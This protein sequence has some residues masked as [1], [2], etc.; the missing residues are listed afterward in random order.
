MTGEFISNIAVIAIAV[1]FAFSLR[2]SDAPKYLIYGAILTA[3]GAIGLLN[4]YGAIALEIPKLPIVTY[5]VNITAVLVGG[6]LMRESL[7]ERPAIRWPSFFLGMAIVILTVVPTLY[8]LNA[9]TFNI[10]SYPGVINYYLHASAG[11]L[12]LV[13]IAIVGR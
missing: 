6:G 10:P 12:L 11:M 4:Y 7:M 13:G 3:V 2:L 8:A 1:G 5:A 9:I